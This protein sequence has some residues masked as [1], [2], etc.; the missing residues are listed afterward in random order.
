MITLSVIMI[1]L[2]QFSATNKDSGC[3][4][5]CRCSWLY[6]NQG[7]TLKRKVRNIKHSVAK[8]FKGSQGWQPSDLPRVCE[9]KKPVVTN[10]NHNKK[11]HLIWMTPSSTF[12]LFTG[13]DI[14]LRFPY[15]PS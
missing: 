14:K 8:S 11:F 13:P 2:F 9:R 6:N 3:S 1:I 5:E 10:K 12:C 7:Q 15:T 4:L